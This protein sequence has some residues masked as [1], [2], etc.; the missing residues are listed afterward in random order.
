MTEPSTEDTSDIKNTL[1]DLE[2]GSEISRIEAEFCTYLNFTIDE[3]NT[4]NT[5]EIELINNAQT[6]DGTQYIIVIQDTMSNL[7]L[8]STEAEGEAIKEH[9]GAITE[10]KLNNNS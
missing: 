2:I 1:L 10:V 8:I 3:Q 6:G 9:H 4:R 7:M 5:G